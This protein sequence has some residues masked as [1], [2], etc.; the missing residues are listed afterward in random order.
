VAAVLFI[1]SLISGFLALACILFR[2]NRMPSKREV[3]VFS[4]IASLWVLVY[5]ACGDSEAIRSFAGSKIGLALRLIAAGIVFVSAFFFVAIIRPR[6][7]MKTVLLS[8]IIAASLMLASGFFFLA[9]GRNGILGYLISFSI[10]FSGFASALLSVPV[11][12]E[13]I[14]EKTFGSDAPLAAAF[15]ALDIAALAI[16]ILARAGAV[17][18]GFGRSGFALLFGLA[19]L[20]AIGF[21][22]PLRIPAEIPAAAEGVEPAPDGMAL[23]SNREMEIAKLLLTGKSYR[24]IG[25]MLFIAPSTVKTHVLRIYEKAGVKNKMELANKLAKRE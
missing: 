11:I 1:T 19:G 9:T 6:R 13:S 20:A 24:E 16:S 7:Y 2:F 15:M 22:L 10:G 17:S 21:N 8:S 23:L 18:L 4:L 3:S 14:R 12:I 5:L 25:E